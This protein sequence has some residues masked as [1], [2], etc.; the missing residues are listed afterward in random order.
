MKKINPKK[1]SVQII[2]DRQ[3]KEILTFL[4]IKNKDDNPLGA[5]WRLYSSMGLTP[6]SN[7]KSISK[8]HLEGRYGY[9][10]P[11]ENWRILAHGEEI[12]I[13]IEN[14]LLSGMQ[15]LKRQGFYLT[16]FQDGEEMML[17]EPHVEDPDLVPLTEPRMGAKLLKRTPLKSKETNLKRAYPVIIPTPRKVEYLRKET[18]ID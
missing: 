14:W 15:L 7:E 2:E 12:K 6:T 4:L 1:I 3:K 10:S 13:R 9:I 8:I 5:N 11:N 16:Q 17:G 18:Q